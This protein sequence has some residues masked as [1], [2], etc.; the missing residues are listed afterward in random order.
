MADLR[1]SVY[2]EWILTA[3]TIDTGKSCENVVVP[4][5]AV[6]S[7]KEEKYAYI[8]GYRDAMTQAREYFKSK[9][10]PLL[11]CVDCNNTESTAGAMA[12]AFNQGKCLCGG[13]FRVVKA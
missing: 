12:R 2:L 10:H 1:D 7:W 3:P 8:Q 9:Q 4:E 11:I 13:A 6:N 5:D